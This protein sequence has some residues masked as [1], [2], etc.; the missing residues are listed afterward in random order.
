MSGLMTSL[1]D[2]VNYWGSVNFKPDP[3]IPD[4]NDKVILVTGGNAGLGR[5]TVLQ[6]AKHNPKKIFLAA[7]SESKAAEAIK[8]IKASVANNVDIS[9]IPLDLMS[10][11]SIKNAAE[12]VNS[13]SSRLDILILNAGVMALPPGETEMGHEIQ[14]G[15][16]HTGHFHLTKLLL[17]T[18]LKTAQEPE[19]DVRIVTLASV[20]QL[21]APQFETIL[22]QEKLKKEYTNVRYGASKAANIM[23]AA[24]LARRYPSITSVAVHPGLIVT[25]L[26]DSFKSRSLLVS[27]GSSILNRTGSTIPQ[28]ALNPLWAATGPKE[29]LR[30]GGYY[31]PV[32][33]LKPRNKWSISKDKGKRLWD[34]TEM[35][36][37]KANL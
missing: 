23:F 24:E 22:N 1:G 31:A 28:G 30:N 26:Y 9:W 16:N 34:W 29:N 5:E 6:L 37:T 35:E 36:L 3:D 25:Q 2:L 12:Q 14:I 8:S 19:S 33:I 32:G 18:L 15:T 10:G 4:L 17:P 13:Q 7:R 11:S 27:L 21:F 20:A